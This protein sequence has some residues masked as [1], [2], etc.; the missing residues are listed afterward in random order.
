MLGKLQS[1]LKNDTD[2]QK[3]IENESLG[4]KKKEG[5][6]ISD[7][8]HEAI[9]NNNELSSKM[10]GSQKDPSEKDKIIKL[11]TS[12]FDK[13]IHSLDAYYQK[14]LLESVETIRQLKEHADREKESAEKCENILTEKDKTLSEK[15]NTIN[16]LK[17]QIDGQ[18]N[19]AEN[20]QNGL[21][22]KDKIIAEKD[23]VI[24][25]LTSRIFNLNEF[26]EEY[27][28]GQSEKKKT[29]NQVPAKALK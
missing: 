18:K 25:Q 24:K 4:S 26:T 28:K 11:L 13:S 20:Y 23:D 16:L 6:T 29:V 7:K 17:T 1:Y 14:D 21:S 10:D 22:E 8:N 2:V 15:E 12:Q 9:I 3:T 5:Y 19:A 27:Q